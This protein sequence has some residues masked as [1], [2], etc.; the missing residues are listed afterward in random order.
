MQPIPEHGPCFV[1]GTQNP[2]SI[3]VTWWARDDGAVVTE[4]TLTEVQQGPPGYAHGGASAALLDEAM[5]AAV[6]RAG[7][8]VVA[9][10]LE[11]EY[12]RLVPL[13][14]PVHVEGVVVE[15][16]CPE[17]GRRNGRAVRTRG[18]IR[19]ADGTVAV[20]A[21]GIYVEAPQLFGRLFYRDEDDGERQEE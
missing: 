3:G 14:E 6:W 5:G 17:P 13:G 10:N 8:T 21:R 16:A 2:H 18:E 4:V 20:V 9:V 11:V 15:K 12:R 19:L 7:Y 1:C